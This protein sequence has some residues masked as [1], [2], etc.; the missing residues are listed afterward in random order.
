MTSKRTLARRFKL[1]RAIPALAA[2]D[3]T[4]LSELAGLLAPLEVAAG[5][6]LVRQGEP[7]DALFLVSKGSFELRVRAEEGAPEALVEIAE[8][9]RG[10]GLL[11]VMAGGSRTHTA[12][13]RE[14]SEVLTIARDAFQAYADR[15]PEALR[16]LTELVRWRLHFAHLLA[17]L[18]R[19][20]GPPT[21]E[22]RALLAE[23]VTWVQ[24][25]RGDTLFRAGDAP[26]ALY[27]V[28]SGQL[29]LTRYGT[30]GERT[31]TMTVRGQPV[32]EISLLAGT[33]RVYTARAHRD[34][35][36]GRLDAALVPRLLSHQRG[37]G[38]A[39]AQH[40]AR[41]IAR[42]LYIRGNDA[43]NQQVLIP[44]HPG[45][46][47]HR[48]AEELARE[49]E[50]IGSTLIISPESLARHGILDA[51]GEL[52]HDHP[53]WLRFTAWHE[54]IS[55]DYSFV[56][57][58]AAPE[59]AGWLR[60]VAGIADKLVFVADAR[61]PARAAP[62][63]DLAGRRASLLL[64][65][66]PGTHRPL[67][68]APWRE[69]P[70]IALHLHLRA[71]D[72]RDAA[73]IARMM[74]GR[75]VGLTLGGGGARGLAHIGVVRAL[76]EAGVPIDYLGGTSMGA[77]IAA[78]V[79]M[80]LSCE[81]MMD[82][83]R[84]IIALKPFEEYTLPMIALLRSKRIEQAARMAFG[85]V[86]IEDLWLPYFA[87]AADLYTTE[88]VV[89]E[90]GPVW[91]ATRASGS[92]PAVALPVPYQGRLLI[93]GGV[94]DNVPLATMKRRMPGRHIAVDVSPRKDES[95]A[96]DQIPS[97]WR[98]FLDR[99]LKL[100]PRQPMPSIVDI[101]LRTTTLESARRAQ[102]VSR[103]ADLFLRPP[104][105][106]YGLLHFDRFEQIVEAA[107][108]Y[109]ARELEERGWPGE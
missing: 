82:L 25:H 98:L 88:L 59:Q 31:T 107:Y 95:F 73:R 72:A 12:V 4:T 76:R 70:Q 28:L 52:P 26:D 24:L 30:S 20:F 84:R 104:V 96:I 21:P 49:L 23:N 32:G 55:A 17:L 22:F 80:R 53:S 92:L 11:Q 40:L 74:S 71:G 85:E 66:P 10:I 43:L 2:I 60:L 19:L 54:R 6:V 100:G 57:F 50:K 48:F 15:H 16:A 14:D 27:F 13:A 1:L 65:H 3:D 37:A 109:T 75:A 102:A 35:L 61:T 90:T 56:I 94:I 5:E 105:A 103:K 9:G 89:M 62:L 44:A 108:R 33:P 63:A 29:A 34:V 87:V 68:T 86:K 39:V 67:D 41:G 46:P 42:P 8:P 58:L 77:I 18:T 78:Q 64:I 101:V 7:G 51:A 38:I 97:P 69:H 93:D 79:A 99:V 36:L 106:D 91:L 47:Y 83:N 45:A 81:E